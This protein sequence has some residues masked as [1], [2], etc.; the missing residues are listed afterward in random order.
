MYP[1]SSTN[2]F[3]VGKLLIYSNWVVYSKVGKIKYINESLLK[4]E[5]R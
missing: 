1:Y 3:K 5:E 2:P 4:F